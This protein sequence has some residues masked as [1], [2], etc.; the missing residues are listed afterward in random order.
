MD[1]LDTPGKRLRWARKKAGY[2]NATAAAEAFGWKVPTYLGHENGDRNPSVPAAQRYSDAFHVP[3]HWILE[4]GALAD[5]PELPVSTVIGAGDEVEPA[6]EG[7]PIDYEPAPPGL[8]DG[9]VTE[10]RGRS[11]LPIFQNGDRLF[12]KVITEDPRSLIGEA[13]V[14]RLKDGR[15]FI[16]VLQPGTKRDRYHL[17]SINPAFPPM[18][19][20]VVV[21]AARIVWVKKAQ[22]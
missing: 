15:R 22:G 3:W 8:Y 10:V 7:N 14:L 4:G 16:K 1:D 9:E 21:S 11:M 6:D 5:S 19:D 20:Q 13:A 18:E 17:V 2:E 12:H